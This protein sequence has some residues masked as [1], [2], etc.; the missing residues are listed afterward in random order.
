MIHLTATLAR[1]LHALPS[2]W[3]ASQDVVDTGI[4]SQGHVIR[5]DLPQDHLGRFTGTDYHLLLE[6]VALGDTKLLHRSDSAEL[7]VWMSALRRGSARLTKTSV[8]SALVVSS[9]ELGHQ[10]GRVITTVVSEDSRHLQNQP[11]LSIV[12][13][14]AP[15]STPCQSSPQQAPSCP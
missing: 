1:P 6:L 8:R 12:G 5:R 13:M 11:A 15:A 10:V 4:V 2:P 3:R 7:H 9:A 14:H